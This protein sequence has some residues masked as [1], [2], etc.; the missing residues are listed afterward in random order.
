[1]PKKLIILVVL[2]VLLFLVYVIRNIKYQKL[3][4]R[5]GLIWLMLILGIIVVVFGYSFF[6]K[7]ANALGIENLSSMSFYIGFLFLIFVCFNIT[8]TISIQN[9]KIIKLTQELGI[10]KNEVKHYEAKQ[11]GNS[12]NK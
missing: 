5:N 12:K 6:E 2:S 3:T 10:L 11:K 4:I 9:Q 1:M 8:K 7:I